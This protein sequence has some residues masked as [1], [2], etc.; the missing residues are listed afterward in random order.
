M[1]SKHGILREHTGTPTGGLILHGLVSCIFITAMPLLP[2]SLEGFTFIL[3]TYTYGH[4]VLNL[5]LALGILFPVLV[6]R[7]HAYSTATADNVLLYRS[8]RDW[9]WQILKWWPTRWACAGFLILVNLFLVI[10]P[11]VPTDNTDGI[12]RKIPTWA[13]PV[14]VL[15]VYIA[16]AVAG[17][18]IVFIC[19]DM[20]FCNSLVVERSV[21]LRNF[22][23]PVDRRWKIEYPEVKPSATLFLSARSNFLSTHRFFRTYDYREVNER[24]RC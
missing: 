1:S 14:T 13:L 3:N 11:F 8:P 17:F 5:T 7:V 23:F 10:L 12:P 24:L 6:H 15:P 4:S 21:T 20:R 19:R 9:S 22:V 16:G 18:L 2:N